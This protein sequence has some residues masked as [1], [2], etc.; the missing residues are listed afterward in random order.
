[1][2]Y[3]VDTSIA[4]RL[5][6]GEPAATHKVLRLPGGV[7]MSI[8]T[9]V[10]LEGG[11]YRDPKDAA[12]RRVRLDTLLATIA[13]VAFEEEAARVYGQIVANLGYSRPRMLDR[14]IAAQ[15]IVHKATLITNDRRGFNGIAS[16]QLEVW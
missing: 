5:R 14:M 13:T 15:A 4:I 9:R 10:E 1:M 11:V 7:F 6:D 12:T 3:M 8:I 2:A 16:L